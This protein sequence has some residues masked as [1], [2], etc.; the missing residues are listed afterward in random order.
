VPPKI[1]KNKHRDKRALS[2]GYGERSKALGGPHIRCYSAGI[3]AKPL[4]ENSNP[5][6][7][8][9]ASTPSCA[10]DADN[11]RAPPSLYDAPEDAPF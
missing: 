1:G 8:Q 7:R 5:A 10:A 6:R 9:G 11:D 3:H 2:H 4:S